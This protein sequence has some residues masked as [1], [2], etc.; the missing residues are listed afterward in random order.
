[1]CSFA[2]LDSQIARTITDRSYCC[3]DDVGKQIISGRGQCDAVD[4][5]FCFAAHHDTV[6]RAVKSA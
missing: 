4:C 3:T 1:M 6:S 2:A 5:K